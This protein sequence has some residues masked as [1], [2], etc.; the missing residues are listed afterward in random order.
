[1]VEAHHI[2]KHTVESEGDFVVARFFGDESPEEGAVIAD[3]LT[4]YLRA[5]P[6]LYVLV[7]VSKVGDIPGETRKLW[8]HWF[9]KH[10]PEAVVVL[11]AGIA[12]RTIAK[13]AAA[14]TRVLFG[15]EPRFVFVESE[16]EGR[17][18]VDEHRTR[19]RR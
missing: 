15:R 5:Q 1:M 9:N 6:R 16:D 13:M 12:V 7:D 8:L 10:V 14:S 17:A 4:R 18:W 11:G 19:S 3:I 2:G